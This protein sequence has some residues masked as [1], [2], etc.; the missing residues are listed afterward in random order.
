MGE[1]KRWKFNTKPWCMWSMPTFI[2]LYELPCL[3]QLTRGSNCFFSQKDRPITI[4][5]FTLPFHDF[6]VSMHLSFFPPRSY[7][8]LGMM[9]RAFNI[10]TQN[11]GT[12]DLWIWG[13]QEDTVRSFTRKKLFQILSSFLSSFFFLRQGLTMSPFLPKNHYVD[14][15][16]SN[17]EICLPLLSKYK[18]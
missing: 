6:K 5:K 2:Q 8:W 7:F 3:P 16:S 11:V 17:S 18:D 1:R 13:S 12:G 14:S 4:R 9:V 15:L 10:S